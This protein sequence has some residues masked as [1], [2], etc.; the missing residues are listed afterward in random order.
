MPVLLP[1]PVICSG[2]GQQVIDSADGKLFLTCGC[3]VKQFVFLRQYDRGVNREQ[4]KTC[5]VM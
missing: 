5:S 2:A 1:G 4:T 3:S